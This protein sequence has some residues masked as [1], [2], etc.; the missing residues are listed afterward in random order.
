MRH[1]RRVPVSIL[2]CLALC[3]AASVPVWAE[4]L[5]DVV[6]AAQNIIEKKYSNPDSIARKLALEELEKIARSGKTDREIIE[7][8]LEKFPETSAEMSDRSDLNSNGIP[9]EWEKKYNVSARFAAPESDEDA[10]GFSLLQEYRAETDPLDPLSHPKYITQIYVSSVSRQ[11]F[12]DME[13]SYVGNLYRGDK[14][15]WEAAFNV[16]RNGNRKV[17]FLRI[18][19]GILIM[20]LDSFRIVDIELVHDEKTRTDSPVVYI[21]RTDRD[22]RIPCRPGQPIY[23]PLYRV[24]FLN[25]LDG[26]AITG[27]VGDTFKL[28]SRKTG[29]ETYRIV[30]ADLDTKIVVVESVGVKPETFKIPPTPS[31]L[32]AAKP[33]AKASSAKSPEK[34]AAPARKPEK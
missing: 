2:F 16:V 18:N 19:S 30:S 26:K 24:K 32:P 23:D 11:R 20:K 12:A 7:A 21:R 28:G 4:N 27:Q 17:E 34:S 31:E 15:N 13:L 10:D 22:E 3:L 1:I 25:A 14:Y 9:D 29:E 33:A 6:E 5:L 8:I